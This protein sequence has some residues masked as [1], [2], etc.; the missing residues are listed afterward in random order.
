M[1]HIVFLFVVVLIVTSCGSTAPIVDRSNQLPEHAVRIANDDLEYEII[2][3]D[4]GFDTY[5]LS[6]AKPSNFYS[7][8]YYEQKNIFY[9]SEW[10]IRAGNPMRYDPSL[11]ENQIA[12]EQGIDYGLDVNY[13]LYNYFKFVEYKYK[14]RFR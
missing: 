12:Y 11:Y 6:I 9:V 1:K 4:I 7:Q 10:N 5:L 14:V 8:S 13:K 2:I 3:I